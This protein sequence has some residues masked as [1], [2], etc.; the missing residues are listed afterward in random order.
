MT[1]IQYSDLFP[2]RKPLIA[3]IHLLAL[4]GAPLYDGNLQG[5]YD[6]AIAETDIFDQHGVDALIEQLGQD[7]ATATELLS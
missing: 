1:P 6:R 3:C 4:P 5:I 7:I 2:N